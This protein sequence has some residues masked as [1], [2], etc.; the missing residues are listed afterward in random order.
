[1]QSVLLHPGTTAEALAS[2]GAAWIADVRDV[3][4]PSRTLAPEERVAIYHGMVAARLEG[5]LRTQFPAVLSAIGDD[6]FARLA[7]AYV[8]ATPSRSWT[9]ARLGDRL[10]LFLERWD[11]LSP[12]EREALADLARYELSL[13]EA[14]D[15]PLEA[16]IGEEQIGRVPADLWEEARLLPLPSLRILR[17][18][19]DAPA[20][21]A[22]LEA[23][24]RVPLPRKRL[25]LLAVWR[26][27][28]GVRSLALPRRGLAL[29]ERLTE[30]RT[31]SGAIASLPSASPRAIGRW[32]AE[33]TGEGLF[34]GISLRS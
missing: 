28:A 29:L 12:P 3:V 30:G 20:A 6:A 32:L 21:H 1:M 26:D 15:L 27:R 11:G 18:A 5:T 8:A 2:P 34:A 23:K 7:G 10:P 22:E 33:W 14:L 31:L 9:L 13:D 19:H 4:L 16:A 25:T 24:R 17:L